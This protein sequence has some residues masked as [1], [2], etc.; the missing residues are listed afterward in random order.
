[1]VKFRKWNRRGKERRKEKQGRKQR[2]TGKKEA[3]KTSKVMKQREKERKKGREGQFAYAPFMAWLGNGK[4]GG[5]KFGKEESKIERKQR[6]T[7][8]QR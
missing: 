2:K 8:K 5:N 4:E 6:N 1:M 3:K 7:G